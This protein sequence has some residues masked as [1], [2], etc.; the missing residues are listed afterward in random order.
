MSGRRDLVHAPDALAL[1]VASRGLVKAMGGTEAAAAAIA[2]RHQRMSDIGLP[3]TPDFMR[4]DEAAAL[5]E[6]TVGQPGWPHV[7][8][9]LAAR[10]HCIVVPLP[11]LPLGHDDVAEA[12]SEIM[13]ETAD[14]L[15]AFGTTFADGCVTAAE[16]AATTAQID[17]AIVALTKA[18]ALVQ[19]AVK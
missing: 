1:K 15:T 13:R 5:E 2:C 12:V 7:T 17:E 6:L 16:S 4:I 9:A 3:N 19:D 18:R 14:V 8:R 11:S 10:Q